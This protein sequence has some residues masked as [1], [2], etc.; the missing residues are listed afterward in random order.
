MTDKNKAEI[1]EDDWLLWVN[2][3][4]TEIF[5]WESFY[6]ALL[7]RLS[8]DFILTPRMTDAEMEEWKKN[9]VVGS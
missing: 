3:A 9:M 5:P 4:E 2:D 6:Q 7:V 1:S 8:Q